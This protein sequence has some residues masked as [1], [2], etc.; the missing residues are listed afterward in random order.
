MVKIDKSWYIKPKNIKDR[1]VA[2][3]VV[4]RRKDG[5]R[6]LLMLKAEH[7]KDFSLPKGGVKDG[8]DVICTARREILEETGI[9]DLKFID[10]LGTTERLTFEKDWWSIC[11]YFLFVTNQIEGKQTL[12]DD[13][14]FS[15]EW[16]DLDNLPKFYW[17]EQK[18]LIEKNLR[19]IK[20]L[21]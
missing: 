4:I 1:S 6:F 8:E 9:T 7:G 15:V 11:Q 16:F 19:R 18:K 2:G 12:E 20:D 21:T 14:D 5:K 17:P 3:G 13:E 10:E